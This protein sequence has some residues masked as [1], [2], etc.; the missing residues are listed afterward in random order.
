MAARPWTIL[1]SHPKAEIYRQ[2]RLDPA[3]NPVSIFHGATF[4][5]VEGRRMQTPDRPS[6]G[7]QVEAEAW[8]GKQTEGP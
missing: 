6:W 7:S 8:F 4:V 2:D 1:K 5:E 3:G